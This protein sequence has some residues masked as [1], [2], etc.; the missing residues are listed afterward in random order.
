MKHSD[1]I[2]PLSSLKKGEKAMITGFTTHHND[3]LNRLYELGFINGSEITACGKA[4]FGDPLMFTIHG[5]KLA[6]RKGDA[7]QVRGRIF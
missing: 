3:R 5:G 2:V 4:P 7:K 1:D 6:L